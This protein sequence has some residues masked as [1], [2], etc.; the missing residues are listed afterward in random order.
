M[1]TIYL[2]LTLLS[3]SLAAAAQDK[4]YLTDSTII[5]AKVKAISRT[6]VTYGYYGQSKPD[7][8]IPVSTIIKIVYAKGTMG[9]VEKTQYKPQVSFSGD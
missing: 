5:E 4:I 3:F 9:N 6:S 8:T 1:K 2:L 7:Q